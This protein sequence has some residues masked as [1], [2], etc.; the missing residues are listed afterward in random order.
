MYTGIVQATAHIAS[1][2]ALDG[3]RRIAVY[4][5]TPI[6]QDVQRG[7]SVSI[8]GTC[9]TLVAYDNGI[10]HFDIS[11]RT[12]TISTLKQLE[13]GDRVNIERSHRSNDE[14]GGHALY[15]HI[16]GVARI[17]EWTG[18]GETVNATIVMPSEATPYL[19]RKGF[20]GLQGCSLTIDEVDEA[21]HQIVVNLIPETLRLT[22]L[23]TMRQGDL[24][25]YEIDQTTRSIVDTIRRS[26]KTI[27][28]Y[29]PS[30]IGVT[31]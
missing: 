2:V 28:V 24:L 23:G 31:R 17:V 18:R 15:G 11:D 16:D 4:N 9:L 25:N 29:D 26:L 3:V 13:I 10:A 6:F 20:V 1:I 27:N 19:F 21:Q 8:N 30:C 7:A 22:T 5:E 14:N 12:A